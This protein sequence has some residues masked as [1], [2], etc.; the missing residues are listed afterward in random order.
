MTRWL[1][2]ACLLAA[3]AGC[4]SSS[5]SGRPAPLPPDERLAVL[6]WMTGRWIT[7]AA[8]SGQRSEEIWS[9]PSGGV[10]LGMARTFRDGKVIFFEY[11]RI[12]A[13]DEGLQY[14]AQPRGRPPVAFPLV[15]ADRSR[16]VFE[17]PKHDFPSRITYAREQ[18]GVL[19]ARIEGEQRGRPAT[20]AWTF[21]AAPLAP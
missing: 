9:Q 1:I 4:A 14:V 13:S 10:M 16:V 21:R 12:E 19:V 5:R 18:P 8:A 11:L 6:D 3:V 20:E 7:D 15:E 2:S 17:N